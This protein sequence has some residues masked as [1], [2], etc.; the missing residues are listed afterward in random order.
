MERILRHKSII[1]IFIAAIMLMWPAFYNGFPLIFPDS[2]DYI[3][4]SGYIYRTP[5]YAFFISLSSLRISLFLSVFAQGLIVSHLIWLI[6]KIIIGKINNIIFIFNIFILSLVSSLPYFASY[7]LADFFTAIEFL[8]LYILIFA[9]DKI[10][11]NT[12]IYI[13]IISIFGAIAHIANL[14]LALGLIMFF[15]IFGIGKSFDFK[16][17][18]QNLWQGFRPIIRGFVILLLINFIGYKSFSTAPVGG[19]FIFANLLETGPA[20]KML[21][22]NCP[23]SNFKICNYLLELP[24]TGAKFLWGENSVNYKLGEFE[25]FKDEANQLVRI[26]IFKYADETLKMLV[27]NFIATWSHHNPLKEAISSQQL[28]EFNQILQDNYGQ[29]ALKAYLNSKEMKDELPYKI[30]KTID[31][32]AFPIS[33]LILIIFG[34]MNLKNPRS[35]N[36][37]LPLSIVIFIIGDFLLCSFTSGVYDRYYS[38]VT[39]LVVFGALLSILMALQKKPIVAP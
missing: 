23:N 31:D 36:F 17:R 13:F 28:I 39:W 34:M 26:V 37:I 6:Q 21:I 4:N 9:G 18:L 7:I 35:D 16:I 3:S 27:N 5:F 22:E 32:F 11:K 25:G 8:C 15:F 38:R 24:Q 14:Y 10:G 2:G 33:F 12:K 1:S 30:T 29:N 19:V 20:K